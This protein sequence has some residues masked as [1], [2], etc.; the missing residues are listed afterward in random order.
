MKHRN[1][2]AIGLA[3]SVLGAVGPALADVTLAGKTVTVL[4]GNRAGGGTDA[5]ARVIGES[6]GK[7]LPGAPQIV[8]RN[9]PGGS[10]IKALNYFASKGRPDGTIIFVGSSSQANPTR[11]QKAAA[12]FNPTT[13]GIFGGVTRG[14]NLLV[15]SRSALPRLSDHKAKPVVIAA[16]DGSRSGL[17]MAL[18]GVELFNWNV[19]WVVGYPGTSAMVLAVE[20]GEADMTSTGDL[21]K[22]K[23]M[24]EGGKFVAI[25]QSGVY[26]EGNTIGRDA[27]FPDVPVFADMLRDKLKGADE[28]T[29]K[30]FRAWQGSTNLDKWL[31]LPPNTH[32]PVVA[33]YRAAYRSVGKDPE[34]IKLGKKQ[35]SDAFAPMYGEAVEALVRDLG[36]TNES[37]IAFIDRLRRQQGLPVDQRAK[38]VKVALEDIKRGGRILMFKVGGKG[39]SARVSSSKTAVRIAGK[40][41]KR[42]ALKSGMKCEITYPG[43]AQVA[44]E[45]ACR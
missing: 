9:M 3:A 35:F 24:M 45:V 30:A 27:H 22:L 43:N 44:T 37:T 41:A 29:R 28:V 18:W 38:S 17:Q 39:Q 40:K 19:K 34:F 8:Y 7:H 15:L 14:G 16:G 11:I 32:K 1:W 4:I 25:A 42:A 21:T 13:F 6:I 2:I 10:G 26:A 20:R 36:D 5:V 23:L 31:A 33:M 12:Q